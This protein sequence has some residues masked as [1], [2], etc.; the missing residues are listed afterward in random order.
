MEWHT[1]N[2]PRPKKSKNEQIKNQVHAHLLYE[3]YRNR[4]QRIF[5]PGKTVN[6]HFY[7]E[8]LEKLRKPVARMRPDIK[9][10][11]VVHHGNAPCHTA[12]SITEFLAK[13]IP[14]V[15]QP[16]CSPDLSPCDFFLFFK[17]EEMFE[18]SSLRHIEQHPENCN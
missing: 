16:P 7:R 14:V 3:Q 15:S 9:E 13:F 6:Q 1:A 18:R 12:L 2:S 10:K 11:W 5:T 17:F 4:P 8:V